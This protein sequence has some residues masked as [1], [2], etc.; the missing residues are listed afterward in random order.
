MSSKGVL[1]EK[2][3][4]AE[5]RAGVKDV[6]ARFVTEAGHQLQ[7]ASHGVGYVCDPGKTITGGFD[8]AH[9]QR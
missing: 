8:I 5:L 7:G 2:I 9:N 4:S 1:P 6:V 3:Q